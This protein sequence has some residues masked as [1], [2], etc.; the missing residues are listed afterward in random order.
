VG[1]GGAGHKMKQW[2]SWNI[3][4]GGFFFSFKCEYTKIVVYGGD[5][6]LFLDS[7]LKHAVTD[8]MFFKWYVPVTIACFGCRVPSWRRAV[9]GA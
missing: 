5:Y 2:F 4:N 7:A 1:V 6:V 8:W 9:Q 3:C